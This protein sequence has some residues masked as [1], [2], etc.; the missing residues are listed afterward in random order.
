[1]RRI[2]RKSPGDALKHD[3]APSPKQEGGASPASR[4]GYASAFWIRMA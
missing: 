2:A 4:V 3:A 1:M